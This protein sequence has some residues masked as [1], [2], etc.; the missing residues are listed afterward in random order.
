MNAVVEREEVSNP[1]AEDREANALV[2]VESSRAI[3]EVQAAYVVARKFPRNA[4]HA[5]DMI[6]RDCTLPKLAEAATYDYVKGGSSISAPTIRLAEAVA[7]RWG[8][9]RCGVTELSRHEGY[10]FCKAFA[11]DLETGF[12]DERTF[13]VRH[14]RET[15]SG[16]YELTDE[17]D[18]YELIANMGSRRKRACIL[19]IIPMDVFDQAVRACEVTLKNKVEVTDESLKIL[20]EAFEKYHVTREMI[21]QRIQRRWDKS[22]VTPG[23]VMQLKRIY[24]SL[25]DGMSKVA[26]WFKGEVPSAEARQE[27]ASGRKRPKAKDAHADPKPAPSPAPTHDAVAIATAEELEFIRGKARAATITEQEICRT[28]QLEK[29]EAMRSAIVPAVIKWLGDPTTSPMPF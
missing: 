19:S 16:G 17:R 27:S 20:L 12:S 23:M 5:M 28:F 22:T 8:N 29:L 18:I 13:Q 21:E 3:A 2:E 15:R 4:M 26:D 14:W 9:I 1:F 25:E 11:E 24:N 7:R 10:S 6:L